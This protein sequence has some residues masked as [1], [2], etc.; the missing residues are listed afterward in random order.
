ML[1]LV[2][3][4]KTIQTALS[5]YRQVFCREAGFGHISRYISGLLLSANKTLQGIYSQWVWAEEKPVSR[6]AMHESVFESGWRTEVLMSTH[7]Q[8][9]APAHRGRG[10]AVLSLNWTFSHH[11]YSSQIFAAKPAYDYVKGCLSCYQTVVTAAIANPHRVDGLAVEAQFPN[12]EKEELAY[13][14]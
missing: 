14:A 9:V 7:R 2:G 1:P 6:R 4:P 3:I 5:S 10:R 13:L 8:V 11:P 12:Y